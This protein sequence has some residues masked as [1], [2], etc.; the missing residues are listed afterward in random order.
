MKVKIE[1]LKSAI[2]I[3]WDIV[4]FCYSDFYDLLEG[5]ESVGFI[6]NL[7]E[8]LWGVQIPFEYSLD[9]QL[10]EYEDILDTDDIDK[11]IKDN[12]KEFATFIRYIN[13]INSN[14]S[15]LIELKNQF[16]IK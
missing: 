7:H 9:E 10:S 6:N 14:I 4:E 13:K 15:R 12:E 5:L 2:K 1:D 16:E 11:A 8:K 3:G